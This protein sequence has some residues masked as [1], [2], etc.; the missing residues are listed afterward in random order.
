MGYESSMTS[1]KLYIQTNVVGLMLLLQV[2]T[3]EHYNCYVEYNFVIIYV[4]Y[5]LLQNFYKM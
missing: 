5:L 1:I 2:R 3:D 4:I